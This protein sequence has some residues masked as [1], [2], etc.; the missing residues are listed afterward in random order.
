MLSYE[1]T[2]LKEE[3]LGYIDAIVQRQDKAHYLKKMETFHIENASRRSLKEL[4]AHF[5]TM[6]SRT[7]E[8]LT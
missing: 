5:E 4:M 6:Q 3:M 1:A 8:K 7:E 2:E